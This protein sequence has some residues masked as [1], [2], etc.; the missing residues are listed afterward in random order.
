[1]KTRY[2]SIAAALMLAIGASAAWGETLWVK[3]AT[4]DLREGKGAIFP[5]VATIAKG[6]QVTVVSRD[7]KWVQVQ[8]A[9]KTGW[10]FETALS[11]TM[12]GGDINLMPSAAADMSTGAA[13]R[14][15]AP[16]AEAYA[17]SRR[18]SKQPLQNLVDLRKTISPQEWVAF[19]APV[20]KK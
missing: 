3:S 6:Q 1:M 20:T 17:S 19:A 14:G 9:G 10:V 11:S 2:A 5:S 13:S 8:A 16:D 15:L 4:A 12:V 7:G 18:M